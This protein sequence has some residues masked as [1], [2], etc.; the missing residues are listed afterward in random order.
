MAGTVIMRPP[1]VSRG[2]SGD[3]ELELR[4]LA[5]DRRRSGLVA[6]RDREALLGAVELPLGRREHLL[7]VPAML[8]DEPHVLAELPE[9]AGEPAELAHHLLR[10]RLDAQAA[11]PEHDRLQVRVQRARRD[12]NDLLLERIARELPALVAH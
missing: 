2:R 8:A 1:F 6:G 11:K 9:V 7:A 3:A 5:L 4:D 10:L 12:R